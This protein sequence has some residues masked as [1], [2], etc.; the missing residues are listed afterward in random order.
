[1][2]KLSAILLAGA[3][4]L[5]MVGCQNSDDG[6]AAGAEVQW[7]AQYIRTNGYSEAVL[8][9]SV[10]II[11]SLQELKD[12]YNVWHEVF[13]LERREKV[14]SDTT[15]GF[16]DACDHYDDAFF[17]KNYL[18]FVLFEEGSGTI[19]HE[20]CSVIQTR[21]KK[22][23]ISVDRKVPEVGTDDMAQWHIILQLSKV[24]S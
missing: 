16:L 9:P 23:A 14:Y 17:E 2:K 13:D 4:L 3:L 20:V 5:G 19:R 12:Y 24:G 18:I 6:M 22:I 15:I 10:R 7:C 21:D 8:F 1:M 11:H